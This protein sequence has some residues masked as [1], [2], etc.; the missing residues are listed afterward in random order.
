MRET[1]QA[2][3]RTDTV[4]E[5]AGKLNVLQVFIP[6]VK[7]RPLPDL[8]TECQAAQC[9]AQGVDGLRETLLRLPP[10][11]VL[12]LEAVK[13]KRLKTLFEASSCLPLPPLEPIRFLLHSLA[14]DWTHATDCQTRELLSTRAVAVLSPLPF[15]RRFIFKAAEVVWHAISQDCVSFPADERGAVLGAVIPY[16]IRSSPL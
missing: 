13:Q 4:R 16:P 5:D 10:T 9:L 8:E 1:A 7:A 14:T 3:P 11:W 12:I 2:V 6:D 15:T